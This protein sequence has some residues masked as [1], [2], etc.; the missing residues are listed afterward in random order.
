M[1]YFLFALTAFG[2]PPLTYLLTTNT[3]LMRYVVY[4]IMLALCKFQS[5]A[6]NFF[7]HEDY[8]GSARG[9]EVSLIYLLSLTF[10][11]VGIAKGKLR[12]IFPEAGYRLYALYF[13]LCLPSLANAE[14]RLISWLEIWKMMMVFVVYLAVYAYLRT[15]NDFKTIIKAFLLVIILNFFPVLDQHYFSARYQAH[16]LF[17]HWNCMAMALHLFGTILFARF[18]T[19]GTRT[20]FDKVCFVGF[21]IAILSTLWSY[22]RG[23]FLVMPISY[24][25]T[26]L[27]CMVYSDK[28]VFFRR[29]IPIAAVAAIGIVIIMPRVIA[30]FVHAPQASTDTRVE[31]AH[32]AWEMI[33]DKPMLG[34]GINNW[35]LKMDRENY[36][37]QTMASDTMGYEL[38]YKGIVETVYLLV[39][40]E[41][42]IP[43]LI[44]MVIWF[45]W[46]LYLC[47]RLLGRLR[48]TPWFFIPAGLLG[49]LT[50][51]YLQSILEWVLRQQ[52]N[53]VCLVF[54]FATLAYLNTDWKRLVNGVDRKSP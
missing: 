2:V 27:A 40:A 1:K 5:T 4:A 25:L 39:G 45:L 41:C 22:S 44:A 18:L 10:I 50:A 24:G 29:M 38:T 36:P 6:I 53:L 42:G 17:P 11:F 9:M 14:D 37:Y 31:L 35:S 47:V 32:C 51:N 28:K 21:C 8:H 26:A 15:T 43:A 33:K 13:L 49:G 23:A 16:G 54:M 48:G 7:S 46:Y 52:M 20:L 12:R 19:H 30:R 3:R 34:V